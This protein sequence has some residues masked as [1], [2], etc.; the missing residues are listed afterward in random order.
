[1]KLLKTLFAVMI[2]GI[3]LTACSDDALPPPENVPE[4]LT[5]EERKDIFASYFNHNISCVYGK[6]T[7][8]NTI[9]KADGSIFVYQ[10]M[11][12]ED[13][14][15]Y[16]YP[17]TGSLSHFTASEKDDEIIIFY[18]KGDDGINYAKSTGSVNKAG[19]FEKAKEYYKNM[20][21]VIRENLDRI[22]NPQVLTLDEAMAVFWRESG[23]DKKQF[24]LKT[25]SH[26]DVYYQHKTNGHT[27]MATVN[28]LC[29]RPAKSDTVSI[30]DSPQLYSF[31]VMQNRRGESLPFYI[32]NIDGTVKTAENIYGIVKE[33]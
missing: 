18:I 11:C 15:S 12:Q 9:T 30:A 25:G 27:V 4:G 10:P 6:Y 28:M 32:I 26:G 16:S 29:T 17:M 22:D 33:Q 1:M 20:Q 13:F 8:E 5:T 23:L 31:I 3:F 19:E 7:D 21:A 24:L 2:C 14:S